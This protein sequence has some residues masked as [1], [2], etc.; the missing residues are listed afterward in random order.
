MSATGTCDA[1]DIVTGLYGQYTLG[2]IQQVCLRC[3]NG[4]EIGCVGQGGYDNAPGII[5]F[6]PS[7]KVDGWDTE[8]VLDSDGIKGVL[9]FMPAGAAN[10]VNPCPTGQKIVGYTG[11]TNTLPGNMNLEYAKNIGAYNLT[12]GY[13]ADYCANNLESEYCH[14]N[15]PSAAILN[16]A[17]AKNMTD[18]CRNR[19]TELNGTVVEAYCFPQSSGGALIS[20]PLCSCYAT[21]PD[22]LK[23]PGR[24]IPQCWNSDCATHG[25]V[26]SPGLACPDVTI[27]K[28]DWDTQGTGNIYK[29]T[30]QV[31][32]CG[33]DSGAITT[34]SGSGL[35]FTIT[36]SMW[37][38]I[39]IIILVI[40]MADSDDTIQ[41]LNANPYIVQV[42]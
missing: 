9:S 21:P 3:G 12:C 33:G 40:L 41:G 29:D 20:D 34:G 28:Q 1:G 32:N 26:P 19:R 42:T 27:C 18:T 31:I 23:G 17:C 36:P 2:R 6:D 10:R 22:A 25:Y 16:E 35:G 7:P 37:I 8:M 24:S 30:V 15:P 11:Y 14:I 13:P 4:K 39:I 38:I 5:N